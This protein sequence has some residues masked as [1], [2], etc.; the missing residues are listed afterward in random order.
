M[1]NSKVT[2]QIALKPML[3]I[4]PRYLKVA[5]SISFFEKYGK[6]WW[7]ISSFMFI[8]AIFLDFYFREILSQ[9]LDL[10]FVIRIWNHSIF[11]WI[12]LCS[13]RIDFREFWETEAEGNFP[14][15]CLLHMASK[16][17]KKVDNNQPTTTRVR[18][19][20]PH[21]AIFLSLNR[22]WNTMGMIVG[23]SG[24]N[25]G[26]F[27]GGGVRAV[28]GS[29]YTNPPY[30]EIQ[31]KEKKSSEPILIYFVRYFGSQVFITTLVL[32]YKQIF[33]GSLFKSI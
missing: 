10:D 29:M 17:N 15:R 31:K 24:A 16:S 18:D 28:L 3:L 26:F 23:H 9:K 19:H 11:L 6:L 25:F 7:D 21:L 8:T 30:D 27:V 20:K 32:R 22:F 14:Q 2:G 5:P 4:Q 13:F 12:W 33:E 1:F